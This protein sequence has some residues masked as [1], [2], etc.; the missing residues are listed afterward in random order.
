MHDICNQVWELVKHKRCWLSGRRGSAGFTRIR[1]DWLQFCVPFATTLDF[2]TQQ[3]RMFQP[4]AS[5]SSLFSVRDYDLLIREAMTW[6][7]AL[8]M[9]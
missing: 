3:R 5:D 6:R 9:E 8:E 7:L 2:W 4:P 1:V